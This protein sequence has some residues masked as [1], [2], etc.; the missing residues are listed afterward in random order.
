[1][2]PRRLFRAYHR[3]MVKEHLK[4]LE[5]NDR[6][7]RFG[8]MLPND[9]IENYVDQSWDESD[10]VWFGVIQDGKVI[11][12]VH[13]AQ[14]KHKSR[15]ELGLSVDPNWRGQ[16]LGQAL[17]DRAVYALKARDVRDVFMHCLAE[18]TIVKHIARKN[19]MVM[20]TEYGETDADLIL[21]ESTP[22]DVGTNLLVEQLA[23]YDNA[24]RNSQNIFKQILTPAH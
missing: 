2:I 23:L 1:M 7:L 21:E 22:V 17:F 14:E 5:G 4:L 11:A 13:I 3:T 20:V 15:A 18:N 16:R 12:A 19:K 8:V 9:A 24:I 6:R 10:N